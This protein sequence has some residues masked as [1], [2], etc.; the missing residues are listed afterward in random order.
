[1]ISTSGHPNRAFHLKDLHAAA[2]IEG[3]NIATFEGVDVGTLDMEF[4][5]EKGVLG[6][7]FP[8]TA[9]G[10]AAVALSHIILLEQL[11][12]DNTAHAYMV[13]EDDVLLR[14]NF[15]SDVNEAIRLA[16]QGW[17]MLNFGCS[18]SCTSVETTLT[19]RFFLAL[20][21]SSIAIVHFIYRDSRIL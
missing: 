11:F 19:S 2:A 1:M 10:E 4:L 8:I 20:D 12:D 14:P 9:R 17:Q 16:P 18:A 3:L 21:Y 5:K 6:A 15:L 7:S 13:L